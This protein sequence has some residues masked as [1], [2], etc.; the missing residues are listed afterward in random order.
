MF[1]LAVYDTN[2]FTSVTETLSHVINNN[3]SLA[4]RSFV[5]DIGCQ[6][7][8]D[9]KFTIHYKVSEWNM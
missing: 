1:Y 8:F 3:Y 4:S 5:A 9:H 7:C 2:S 6:K